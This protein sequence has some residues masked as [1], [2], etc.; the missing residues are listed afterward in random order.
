MVRFCW[1][2][3]E[4]GLIN[5]ASKF[6]LEIAHLEFTLS[7]PEGPRSI[8]MSAVGAI[9]CLWSPPLNFRGIGTYRHTDGGLS[10]ISCYH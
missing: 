1:V 3:G 4:V 2:D 7:S 8:L 10:L 9:R 5:L 6:A